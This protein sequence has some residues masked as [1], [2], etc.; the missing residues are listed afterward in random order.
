MVA[1]LWSQRGLGFISRFDHIVPVKPGQAVCWQS[2]SLPFVQG[3]EESSWS[4]C[5]TGELVLDKGSV[6]VI[7]QCPGPE[8]RDPHWQPQ[9][10]QLPCWLPHGA[11]QR[12]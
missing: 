11:A 10:S 7:G 1:G 12:S 2:L 8:A 6:A 3:R 5:D 9:L 4:L